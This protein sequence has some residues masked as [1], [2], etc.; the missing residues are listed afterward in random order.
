MGGAHQPAADGA[1]DIGQRARLDLRGGDDFLACEGE[2]VGAG[3]GADDDVLVSDAGGEEGRSSGR[4]E[5]LDDG[6]IPSGVDYGYAEGGTCARVRSG[7]AGCAMVRDG[8][9]RKRCE[10]AAWVQTVMFLRSTRSLVRLHAGRFSEA[11]QDIAGGC[12][13]YL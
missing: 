3:N 13:L 5:G 4:D 2:F 1:G 9:R 6:G 8:N 10:A 11:R 12:R 7:G